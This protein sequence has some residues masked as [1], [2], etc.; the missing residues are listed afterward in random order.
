MDLINLD[1]PTVVPNDWFI[2]TYPQAMY[3]LRT[4]VSRLL[5]E[6]GFLE[7]E[8]P[9]EELHRH[10]RP[11]QI[12]LDDKNFNQV[13]LAF[14]ETSEKFRE[15]YLELIKY[16]GQEY[17]EF[18]F[19]YQEA[20]TIRFHM[21][22]PY[23]DIY[24]TKEGVHL[25]YHSDTMLGHPFEEVNCW[26]PLTSTHDTNGLQLSNLADGTKFL[27]SLCEDINYNADVYHRSGFDLFFMKMNSDAEFR[28]SVTESC[29]AL[30]MKPGELVFFDPRCI[31]GPKENKEPETRVSLDF[32]LVPVEAYNDLTRTYTSQ[33]RTSRAFARGDVY[34]SKSVREL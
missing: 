26:L 34:S 20:P 12:A 24:R 25:E 10:L 19:I 3:D 30:E 6:K 31:H 17:F 29:R 7:H 4:E 2:G 13:T 23:N 27:R 33:G 22:V 1:K 11:D 32:R 16:I 18:D 15:T 28:E 21:P 5:I 9:L 14:Y 8:V